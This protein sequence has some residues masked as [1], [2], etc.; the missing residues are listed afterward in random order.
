M[1]IADTSNNRIRFVVASTD[2]IYT[3]AGSISEGFSGDEGDATAALLNV[4][5]DVSVDTSGITY[6]LFLY[7]VGLQIFYR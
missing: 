6:L 2:V 3:I 7:A 1:Y 4:P 5:I